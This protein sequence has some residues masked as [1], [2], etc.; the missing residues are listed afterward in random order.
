MRK[1]IITTIIGLILVLLFL[2]IRDTW[3]AKDITTVMLGLTD[4]FFVAG[5]LI[6][7]YSVLVLVNNG[8]TFDML[9]YSLKRAGDIFKSDIEKKINKS[10]YE[11]KMEKMDNPHEY[12]FLLKVGLAFIAL[13]T[14]FLVL[15]YQL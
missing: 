14:V 12:L 6:T 5:T 1:Y 7:C 2:Q 10:F 4:S 13:A 15:Y 11:Y 3:N 9:V 8:G